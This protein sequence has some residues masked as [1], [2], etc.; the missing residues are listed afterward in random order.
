MIH[1]IQVAG[2][3][4]THTLFVRVGFCPLFD[5]KQAFCDGF[6]R[7][8]GH[9]E[10]AFCSRSSPKMANAANQRLLGRP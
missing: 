3:P 10:I 7:T 8:Y 5:R 9:E 1:A 4:G 2:A 6:S